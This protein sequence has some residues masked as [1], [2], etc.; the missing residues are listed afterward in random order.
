MR[1]GWGDRSP[2]QRCDCDVYRRDARRLWPVLT[3]ALAVE[4]GASRIG[5]A[6][7]LASFFLPLGVLAPFC[8][9]ETQETTGS[10]VPGLLGMVTLVLLSCIACIFLRQTPRSPLALGEPAVAQ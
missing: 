3:A 9:A 7:G 2:R 1:D 6:L 4:F 10:Y 5:R 8:V